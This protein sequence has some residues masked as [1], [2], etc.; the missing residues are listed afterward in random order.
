MKF[1]WASVCKQKEVSVDQR[2]EQAAFRTKG[3]TGSYCFAGVGQRGGH[4]LA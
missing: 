2:G 3:E 1:N 4:Y